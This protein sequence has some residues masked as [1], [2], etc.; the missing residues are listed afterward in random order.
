LI[1]RRAYAALLQRVAA[2][3]QGVVTLD[4]AQTFCDKR[5]CYAMRDGQML[6]RDTLHLSDAG[7]RQAAPRLHAAIVALFPR[8]R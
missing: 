5:L 2:D 3:Y 1:I 8:D 4:L 7:S 6:Y